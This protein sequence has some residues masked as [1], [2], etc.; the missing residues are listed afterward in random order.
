MRACVLDTTQRERTNSVIRELNA[1]GCKP[2]RPH[3]KA[4]TCLEFPRSRNASSATTETEKHIFVQRLLS[5]PIGHALEVPRTCLVDGTGRLSGSDSNIQL[6]VT[7][8]ER[9]RLLPGSDS[10]LRKQTKQALNAHALNVNHS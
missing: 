3:C 5:W 8:N 2:V 1:R 10:F 4:A 6:Q 7:K 9:L